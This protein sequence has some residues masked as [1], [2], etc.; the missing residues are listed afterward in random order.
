M[1]I[2][3]IE[4]HDG[5][6]IKI[7]ADTEEDAFA[8]ADDFYANSAP[9]PMR[10]APDVNEPPKLPDG[11][12]APPLQNAEDAQKQSVGRT[13][14][15]HSLNGIMAG[16]GDEVTDR[17]G[18]GIAS[19]YTG[20]K[21]DDLLKDARLNSQQRLA[22]QTEQNPWASGIGEV[23]GALTGA[24]AL[25]TP[26]ALGK[27]AA[28]ASNG[29]R[30]AINAI[31]EAGQAIANSIGSGNLLARAVKGGAAGA[32][33][34]GLYGAGSSEEGRRLQGALEQAPIGAAI[35]TAAPVLFAGLGA[36][37]KK[38]FDSLAR[39]KA[40]RSGEVSLDKLTKEEQ[41]IYNLSLIHI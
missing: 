13:L 4:G 28:I 34:M 39:S 16:W 20:E 25:T 31:P 1:P 12:Y 41:Q 5:R 26:L 10:D 18:A 36:A 32:A 7:E 21:Y 37:A 35:G 24:V 29:V 15:D 40:V 19:L 33:S 23:G 6:K 30:G 8:G 2:Y 9:N 14:L 22:A 11:S 27:G 38:G 17:I 3:T